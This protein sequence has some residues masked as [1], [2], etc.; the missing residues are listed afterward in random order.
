MKNKLLLKS[1]RDVN[2]SIKGL[3]I[4]LSEYLRTVF[5]LKQIRR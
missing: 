1:R 2:N 5:N 3:L 4:I